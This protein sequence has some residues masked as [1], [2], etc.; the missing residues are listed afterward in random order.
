MNTCDAAGMLFLASV[1]AIL[2]LLI[3]HKLD[4]GGDPRSDRFIQDP[5]EQWFQWRLYPDGDVCNWST[6][7]HEMWIIFITL[8][9]IVM[10][11]FIVSN[12]SCAVVPD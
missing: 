9:A 6:C 8:F 3:H 11:I 5:C 2:L 7:S 1:L 10:V 4:H 12:G